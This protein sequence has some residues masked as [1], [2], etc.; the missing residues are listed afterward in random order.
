MRKDKEEIIVDNDLKDLLALRGKL[1][2]EIVNNKSTYQR[3]L[4]TLHIDHKALEKAASF[5]KK[6]TKDEPTKI[7]WKDLKDIPHRHLDSI[8]RL[9]ERIQQTTGSRREALTEAYHD[10]ME[11]V[12]SNKKLMTQIQLKAPKIAHYLKGKVMELN[13]DKGRDR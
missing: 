8:K 4:D 3:S 7:D 11:Q 10:K 13:K 2:N 1:A 6:T 9:G 5:E 12:V